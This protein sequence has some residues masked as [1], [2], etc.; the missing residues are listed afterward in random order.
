MP[1]LTLDTFSSQADINIYTRASVICKSPIG[2]LINKD[3]DRQISLQ[4]SSDEMPDASGCFDFGTM[5]LGLVRS[6]V[7]R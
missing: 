6:K 2:M 3:L 4:S 7:R 1:P 5:I